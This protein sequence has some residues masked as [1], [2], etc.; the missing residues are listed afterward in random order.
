MLRRG[1]G[2]TPSASGSTTVPC[3]AWG[4]KVKVKVNIK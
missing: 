1:A 3:S 2:R 4:L